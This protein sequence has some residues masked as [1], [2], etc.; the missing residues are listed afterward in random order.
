M[1]CRP[2]IA[3]GSFVP[4]VSRNRRLSIIR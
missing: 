3:M 1:V 4:T 2:T